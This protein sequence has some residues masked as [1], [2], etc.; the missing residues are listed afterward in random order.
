MPNIVPQ[1]QPVELFKRSTGLNIITPPEQ[2]ETGAL[3]AAYNVDVLP[4]GGLARRYGHELL[5]TLEQPHSLWSDN[6]VCFVAAEGILYQVNNALELTAVRSGLGP[7]KI[8]YARVAHR[9]YYASAT[10]YGIVENFAHIDW[11][12]S[13]PVGAPEDAVYQLPTLGKYLTAYNGRLY[14]AVD[15]Y[16]FFT[17]YMALNAERKGRNFQMMP[18][19]INFLAASE[20]V[21]WVGT[22][23]DIISLQG[24]GVNEFSY[25]VASTFPAMENTLARVPTGMY[26]PGTWWFCNT[27]Q[28]ICALGPGGAVE[29]LTDTTC[30]LPGT[31]GCAAVF[32]SGKY[33]VTFS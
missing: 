16:L 23:T 12:Y 13:R 20:G 22:E 1:G 28:G 8:Y 18:S 25:Q 17:E 10:N 27:S 3:S 30:Q 21:L 19:R 6:A 29:F 24:G 2:L 31:V 26:K 33:V 32:P 11:V 9:V 5:S 15:S 14:S 4:N 7:A